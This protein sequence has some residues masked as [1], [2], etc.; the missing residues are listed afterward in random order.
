MLS[1]FY[2]WRVFNCATGF[3][4]LR[5]AVACAF[6]LFVSV[7]AGRQLSRIAL[8]QQQRPEKSS[9]PASSPSAS[10]EVDDDEVIKVSTTEVLLPVTVRDAAG[11]LVTTL[12][13]KDF[14]VWENGREQPLSDL[15]LRRVPVDVMLMVD[16]SSSVTSSLE[17]FRR[18]VDEFAARLAP[19]DR[20]SLLKFDDRV[21]LLQDWTTSR[22]QLRRS[23]RRVTPGMFTRF[24]DAL[25]LAGREGFKN[26]P[27]R[28]HA[29]VVLTD[30]ID[31]GRGYATLET[32]LGA[33]LEAGAS[34]YC[35]SNTEIERARKSAELDTLQSTPPATRRFNELRIGD[36]R[37]SLRVLD[38]SERNLSHLTAA[39]GGRLFRPRSLAALDE[40]YAEVAEELRSQYAL[41]YLPLDKTRDGKFRRVQVKTKDPALR[42]TARIG[43]FAPRS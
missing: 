19:E 39:T 28:R 2:R 35:I 38:A 40:I 22:V 12:E 17:D 25:Y 6:A 41:Y 1:I 7:G 29:V 14:Q 16:A 5:L 42:P 8:A 15:R 43:Y 21:E 36:L 18:A 9:P 11:R 13:R 10:Q 31:S 27:Q 26:A 20:V 33:L 37:E 3:R 32:A 23:L 30:G 24:H 34:V 4:F